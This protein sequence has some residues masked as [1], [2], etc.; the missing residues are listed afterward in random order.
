M[1][2]QK[3]PNGMG[4]YD[5]LKDGRVRWRIT[6]DGVTKAFTAKDMAVLKE[7]VKKVSDLPIIKNKIKVE[8][9]F[10]K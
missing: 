8:E 7:K 6:R 4:S 10:D 3:N 5:K 9:W 2:R 1:P